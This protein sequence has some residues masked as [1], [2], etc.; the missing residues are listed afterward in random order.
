MVMLTLKHFA[1]QSQAAAHTD[2]DRDTA[3]DAV[4]DADTHRDTDTGTDADLESH[5]RGD[6]TKPR[7]QSRVWRAGTSDAAALQAR[8]H[9]EICQRARPLAQK[10]LR[11][12]ELDRRVSG[13]T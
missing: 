8:R 13:G 2:I 12:P 7:R 4:A 6:T 10:R 1:T 3:T 5:G 9:A 11:A